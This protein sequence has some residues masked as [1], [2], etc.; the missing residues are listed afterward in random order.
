MRS[1]H[2]ILPIIQ[3]LKDPI[4]EARPAGRQ[5]EATATGGFLP[6]SFFFMFFR[7]FVGFF[8][9]FCWGFTWFYQATKTLLIVF[10]FLVLL[11]F[12]GEMSHGNDYRD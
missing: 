10:V 7:V 2:G 6:T 3:G 8:L 4:A 12:C 9:C 1:H 11:G 5:W